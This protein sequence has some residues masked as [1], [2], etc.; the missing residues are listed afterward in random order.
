MG[1]IGRTGIIIIAILSHCSFDNK[2]GI[3]QNNTKIACYGNTTI[4][5]AKKAKLKIDIKAPTKDYPSMTM[6]IEKYICKK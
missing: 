4:E 6:A 2:T 1:N 5:A 3:W